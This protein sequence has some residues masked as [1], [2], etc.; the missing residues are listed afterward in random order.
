MYGARRALLR[1]GVMSLVML[2]RDGVVVVNRPTNIKRPDQLE[3]IPRA[4]QAIA[5]L[6]AGGFHVVICTNQQEVGRGVMSAAQLEAVHDGLRR[7]L[8]ERGALVE[9]IVCS[10]SAHKA[11]GLKPSGA[12]LR[13]AMRRYGADPAAT[14]YVGD[15]VG[16]LKAA[17]HAGC[18][19][20][21]VRT[22]LGRKTLRRPL[23][24]YV[25]PVAVFDDLF[26]VASHIA[27]TAS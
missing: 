1:F 7:M 24:Q 22:G 18:R 21:L 25:E 17:F 10:G 4:A 8:A 13:H 9:T 27:S 11:P 6:N 23:P 14:A 12:M 3:L 20:V 16:D 19:R 15:Q 26:E 2:D 5:R